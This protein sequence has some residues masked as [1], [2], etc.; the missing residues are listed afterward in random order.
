MWTTK[1]PF[2]GKGGGGGVF[3]NVACLQR[4]LII[5]GGEGAEDSFSVRHLV[6]K[7]YAS[8]QNSRGMFHLHLLMFW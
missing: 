8:A 4:F 7:S 5:W 2:I 3:S 1:L 6:E